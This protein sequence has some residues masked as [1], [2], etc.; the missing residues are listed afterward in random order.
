MVRREEDIDLDMWYREDVSR[1]FDGF[2]HPGDLVRKP[3]WLGSETAWGIVIKV[4]DNES[5]IKE[6]WRQ[7]CRQY[8]TVLWSG[9]GGEET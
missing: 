5:A 9:G 1:L 4:E 6:D 3:S 2:F 7:R 8:V